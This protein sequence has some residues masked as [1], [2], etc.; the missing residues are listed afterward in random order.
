MRAAACPPMHSRPYNAIVIEIPIPILT[1]ILILT[2][3]LKTNIT[4]SISTGGQIHYKTKEAGKVTEHP[5]KQHGNITD[6]GPKAYLIFDPSSQLH[7]PLAL[8]QFFDMQAGCSIAVRRATNTQSTERNGGINLRRHRG[9]NLRCHGWGD[10]P[11]PP[12]Y[13]YICGV[14]NIY[15]GILYILYPV[16]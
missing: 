15:E 7:S 3:K 14:N 10:K 11:P 4:P 8:L 12:L 5:L 1:A 9:I 2:T 16:I 6:S 13:M